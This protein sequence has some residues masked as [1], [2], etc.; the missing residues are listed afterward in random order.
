LHEGRLRG[1]ETEEL[2]LSRPEKEIEA[3]RVAAPL[4][5]END[6]ADNDNKPTLASSRVVN[7]TPQPNHS[8]W[9]TAMRWP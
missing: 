8:G 6:E 4:L 9:D 1:F 3:L 5:S 2:D 7:A